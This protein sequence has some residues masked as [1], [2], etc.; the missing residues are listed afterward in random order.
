MSTRR[1]RSSRRSRPFVAVNCGAIPN[2]LVD[3][4]NGRFLGK[5][6]LGDTLA[7]MKVRAKDKAFPFPYLDD[8]GVKQEVSRAYG[9]EALP[10]AVLVD[11]GGDV[12]ERGVGWDARALEALL[13][14]ARRR[15]G[16]LAP[17]DGCACRCHARAA[18]A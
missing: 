7:E 6:D 10:T 8:G 16:H 13:N 4:S 17:F 3:V 14:E 12:V 5:T 15:A 11:T 2:N 1:R 9:L 18:H